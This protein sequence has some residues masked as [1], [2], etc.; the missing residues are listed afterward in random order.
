MQETDKKTSE[1][2]KKRD[3]KYHKEEYKRLLEEFGKNFTL[4]NEDYVSKKKDIEQEEEASILGKYLEFVPDLTHENLDLFTNIF[5]NGGLLS[6]HQNYL[7]IFRFFHYM[8]Y[9]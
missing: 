4:K 7:A 1:E 5:S 9:K 8:K 6:A 3:Y 2:V